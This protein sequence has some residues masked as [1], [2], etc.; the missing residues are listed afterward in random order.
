MTTTFGPPSGPPPRP[1]EAE[2]TDLPAP[3]VLLTGVSW[4]LYEE[5][6]RVVGDRPIRMSYDRGDLEIMSPLPKHEKWKKII[7]WMVEV[8]SMELDIPMEPLGST[9]FRRNVLAK[10]L[11]PDECYYIANEAAVRNKDEIDLK[12][13]P[14]PDLAIEIELTHRSVNRERIYAG[15]GVPGLWRFDGERADRLAADAAAKARRRA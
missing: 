2:F 12:K 14:P 9:T 7:G 11:E 8:L 13:D 3:G 10:G 15:L 5:L 6:L 4:D 1:A